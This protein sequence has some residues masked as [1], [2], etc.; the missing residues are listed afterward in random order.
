MN[1]TVVWKEHVCADPAAAA[2]FIVYPA[3]HLEQSTWS[4]VSHSVP[5]LPPLSNAIVAVPSGQVHSS[6]HSPLPL[7]T[8][9]PPLPSA[10]VFDEQHFFVAHRTKRLLVLPPEPP[11][12]YN[13]NASS[14]LC[15]VQ[16]FRTLVVDG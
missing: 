16:P 2:A 8:Q 15:F 13:S 4:R 6:L 10:I 11:L 1:F 9:H 5:P 12:G 7:P 14:P 3:S